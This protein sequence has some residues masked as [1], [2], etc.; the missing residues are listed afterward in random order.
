MSSAPL[1]A[2]SGL[3]K[4]FGGVAAVD[5]VD[6]ALA[7]GE[8]R[9]LIG[10]NGAGKSTFFKML[11][12]QLAPTAGR[13]AFDGIDITGRERHEVSRLGIGIKTQVP[14]L[15][16][17]LSVRENVR[18]AARRRHGAAGAARAVDETLALVALAAEADRRVGHLAHGQRQWLE[19]GMVLA[20]A[21]RLLLL[22]EPTAGMT[23][24]E[25]ARTAELIRAIRRDCA[26]IVVEHDMQFVRMIAETV[27]VFHQGRILVEDNVANVLRDARVRD[28]YLGKQARHA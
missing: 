13:V 22:D 9:C 17:G 11:T 5:G 24:D 18:L 6:F 23:R 3:A 1:L 7:E 16:D 20:A 27:T 25:V 14:S 28:V 21:P 10:P 4:H 15:F 8:L 12:G 19:L 26:L 2:T